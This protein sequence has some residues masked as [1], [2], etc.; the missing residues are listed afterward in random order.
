[1]TT[2]ILVQLPGLDG[3]IEVH[4][5]REP[6]EWPKPAAPAT[7]RAALAAVHVVPDTVAENVPGAPAQLDWDA[8]LGFRRHIWSY[9]LGVAEAMDTAQ[10][11]MGMDWPATLE[12]I[13]R[14]AAEASAVG[15]R[16]AAGAC[17]D[18]LPA[19]VSDL[20]EVI[21]AYSDQIAAVE[22]AGAQVV[23]M[24]SR[25]LN[26]VARGADDFLK[27]YDEL[28]S[29]VRAPVILHWLG[30]AFD[31]ALEGYWGSADIPEAT[32][33]VLSLIRDHADRIDG[34]KVSL[35]EAEHEIRLRAA[36]PDGVRTYTG[37]DFNY[38]GLIL[39]DGEHVSDALLGIFAAIAPAASTALQALDRVGPDGSSPCRKR[40]RPL[41]A[42][43]TSSAANGRRR[44]TRRP[45]ATTASASA[46]NSS[47]ATP[48]SSTPANPPC[49]QA[50][51]AVYGGASSGSALGGTSDARAADRDVRDRQVDAAH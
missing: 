28:L 32:S 5:L 16:I 9:G 45:S 40:S 38:P 18:Q 37:D 22:E 12:L 11:G 29:Q 41:T 48:N 23:V 19:S 1:M 47:A 13:N 50:R 43:A 30:S 20:D 25:Q 46:K 33:T 10:R 4:Q 44:P 42:S 31:P 15:G 26:Q 21:A 6:V 34:V 27:V 7:S 2:P 14:S 3:D 49:S 24:A 17:T 36:M 39:G 35:L 8:T 51:G